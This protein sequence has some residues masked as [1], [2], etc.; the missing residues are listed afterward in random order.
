MNTSWK[1]TKLATNIFK[2]YKGSLLV[3]IAATTMIAQNAIAQEQAQEQVTSI[4]INLSEIPTNSK[5]MHIPGGNRLVAEFEV[6]KDLQ[7]KI[8]VNN[9]YVSS[10][11][12]QYADGKLRMLI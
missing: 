8:V 7:N 1:K 2:A 11:S 4:K 10:L 3:G 9:P 6:S 5:I 12:S